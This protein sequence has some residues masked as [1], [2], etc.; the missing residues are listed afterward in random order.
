MNP[1]TLGVTIEDGPLAGIKLV[2]TAARADGEARAIYRDDTYKAAG[3]DA[4]FVVDEAGFF[5]PRS[6]RSLAFQHPGWQGQLTTVLSGRIYFAAVDLRE[7]SPGFRQWF[8]VELNE[9]SPQLFVAPGFA[10]GFCVLS[11]G[12]WVA[13]KLTGPHRPEAR[14]VLRF[15]DPS[16]GIAWP[17]PR[18]IPGPLEQQAVALAELRLSRA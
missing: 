12:A 17:L 3:L 15:D 11:D 10:Q 6:L 9:T 1:D 8:G 2:R 16:V 4:I 7:D 5:P 14:Q 18:A 13:L